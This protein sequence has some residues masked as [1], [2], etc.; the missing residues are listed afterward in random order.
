MPVTPNGSDD[1]RWVPADERDPA[2]IS[3]A[4]VTAAEKTLNRIERLVERRLTPPSGAQPVPLHVDIRSEALP[5]VADLA[6]AGFSAWLR[7]P[8]RTVYRYECEQS[9]PLPPEALP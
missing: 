6:V 9:P 3:N 4:A 1:C 8:R 5:W 2:W 7:A